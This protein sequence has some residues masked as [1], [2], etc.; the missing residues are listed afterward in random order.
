MNAP[1][2]LPRIGWL[3]SAR[4][5]TWRRQVVTLDSWLPVSPWSGSMFY[6]SVQTFQKEIL[7]GEHG[8]RLKHQKDF[9]ST[10]EASSLSTGPRHFQVWTTLHWSILWAKKKASK[11]TA[12]NY[13]LYIMR[14]SQN[15]FA[16]LLSRILSLLV[17]T[18]IPSEEK[19]KRSYRLTGPTT[20]HSA[21]SYNA[22]TR[23]KA[24]I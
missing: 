19:Q 20:L 9:D 23:P 12:L 11:L 6:L 4:L 24:A 18:C 5:T 16:L 10:W 17:A 2:I 22:L 7:K 8:N 1:C 21:H 13:L 3:G 15:L 14:I